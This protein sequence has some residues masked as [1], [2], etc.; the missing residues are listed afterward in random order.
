MWIFIMLFPGQM[1][2]V[3]CDQDSDWGGWTVFQRREDGFLDFYRGWLDYKQ[4]FGSLLGEFWLGNENIH[5]LTADCCHEL[6]IELTDFNGNQ[7]YAKYSNFKVGPKSGDYVVTVKGH[8]GDAGDSLSGH[9]G[10]SF[11]DYGKSTSCSLNC[12]GGWWYTKCHSANLNGLYLRGNH[13]S[14]ADGT[15]WKTWTGYNYSLKFVEMK[16]RERV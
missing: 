3:F 2:Q 8:R 1:F 6:R 16:F 5:H 9:N 13:T 14:Y 7:R 4:G 15:E 10:T 11:S 12:K